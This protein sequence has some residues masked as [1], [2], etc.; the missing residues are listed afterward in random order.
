MELDQ[1]ISG[2]SWSNVVYGTT[3]RN[4]PGV[5]EG[6]FAGFNLGLHCGDVLE[7]AQANRERL[8]ELLPHAPIWLNQ[9]HGITVYDADM[10]QEQDKTADAAV[11][12]RADCVLA[13]MTADCLPVVLS[14][15]QGQV[16]GA[17]HAGWRGLCAGVLE[18]T[19]KVMRQKMAHLGIGQQGIRAWI[20]PA[21][22]YDCFEVGEEVLQAFTEFD[23]QVAQFFKPHPRHV[24]KWF[25]DLP[26]IAKYRLEA[27]DIRE[28]ELSHYC[29][30]QN[31]Q[32]FYSYRREAPTGRLA[33]FVWKTTIS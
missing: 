25:A 9:V 20:G 31:E 5:S 29:T 13:I 19:V 24:G 3:R 30:F 7:H 11:T 21:I 18:E 32:L 22:S 10:Q 17:A 26:A 2:Q 12:T 6:P 8:K 14:D 28:V 15:E 23:Q 33:T 16:I 4:M 27:Q 1:L